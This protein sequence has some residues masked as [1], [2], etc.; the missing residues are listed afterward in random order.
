[1][2]STNAVHSNFYNT[3][4]NEGA[5]TA[6]VRDQV[7]RHNPQTGVFCGS[8]LNEKVRFIVQDAVLDQPTDA[9]LLRAFTHMSLTCDPRAPVNVPDEILKTLPPDLEIATLEAE[10]VELSL[11]IKA[12]YTFITRA[13]GTD[14]GI[15]YLKLQRKIA[16]LEK[17]RLKEIKKEYRRD[18]FYRI[19]NETMKRQLEKLSPEE[20][21]E[22]IIQ[23][24]LP[25]RTQLQEIMCDLS[26]DGS[27]YGIVARR[28]HA[29]NI[30]IALSCRQEPPRLKVHPIDSHQRYP[31][32]ATEV[33][34]PFPLVC[35][36]TQCIICIGNERLPY[37]HRMKTFT[38]TSKMMTHVERHLE[39]VARNNQ[40]CCDHP[41]CKS[42][43]VILENII[44]FKN[45]VER[46]HG[47]RLR[48]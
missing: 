46:V 21:V 13:A 15:E 19:H 37:D 24:Q 36:K 17:T 3:N 11:E 4:T 45:H 23:H 39:E 32:E 9:G 40:Y 43:G 1:M 41:V 20:Y 5:T 26:K 28:I 29:I 42:E 31:S 33:P 44:H 6:A 18:Y 10:R 47:I 34:E 2:V 25:E 35:K 16:S 14:I 30:M 8:Y 27:T 22:P 7:L 12:Q 38:R 48:A